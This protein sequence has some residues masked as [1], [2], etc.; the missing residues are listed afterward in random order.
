MKET[1]VQKRIHKAEIRCYQCQQ[2]GHVAARCPNPKP[3]TYYCRD[4]CSKGEHICWGDVAG[5][6]V[7]I[8]LDTGS[9]RTVVH[10]RLVPPE[11]V[12]HNNQIWLRCAHGDLL[13]YPTA[14]IE[15]LINGKTY[16]VEAA[17]SLSLP[18]P[19]LLG[20]DC[21]DLLEMISK[22]EEEKTAFVL[23]RSGATRME[24]ENKRQQLREERSGVEPTPILEEVLKDLGQIDEDLLETIVKH[25][26]TRAAK[27]K[28]KER[29]REMQSSQKDMENV[30][31]CDLGGEV[32]LSQGK[33]SRRTLHWRRF[34]TYP[35][36]TEQKHRF[37]SEMESFIDYGH[38]GRG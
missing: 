38:Q 15:I 2:L 32:K 11:K 37:S 17:V 31:V 18:K 8:V 30:P 34:V 24:A 9:S 35:K 25:R 12:N 23:T 33:S 21:E 13:S 5:N 1:D 22:R 26:K 19:I 3:G 7:A 16:I 27:R 14:E 29:W 36:K 4:S 28:D 20:R 10:E 6:C